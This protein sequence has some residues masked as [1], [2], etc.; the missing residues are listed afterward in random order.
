MNC[1]S[2]RRLSEVYKVHARSTKVIMEYCNQV[3][4][5]YRFFIDCPRQAVNVSNKLS[6]QMIKV[7]CPLSF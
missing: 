4:F 1:E 7:Q 3:R 5:L 6:W 2:V